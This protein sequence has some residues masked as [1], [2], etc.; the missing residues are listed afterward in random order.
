MSSTRLRHTGI[1]VLRCVRFALTKGGTFKMQRMV[2]TG[3]A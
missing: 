3:V 2:W 1:K